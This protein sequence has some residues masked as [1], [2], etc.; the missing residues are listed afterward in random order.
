MTPERWDRIQKIYHVARA[1]AE[2]DRAEFLADAC[3]GDVALER[4][5]RALLDQPVS[6]SGFVGFLGGPAQARLS[7][8]ATNDLTGRQLGSYRVLSLLGRG[9][10]GEVYR[11]HDAKLG[12]DVAI[13]VLPSMFTADRERVARFDS[14]ARML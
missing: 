3:G 4:E 5:V 14:E 7:D 8:V 11:A 10:M 2:A 9:G 13:K 12:R 1:C 6:T